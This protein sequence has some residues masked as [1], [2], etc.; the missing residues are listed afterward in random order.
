MSGYKIE[1][2]CEKCQTICGGEWYWSID[3]YG[4]QKK[5]ILCKVE[6]KKVNEFRRRQREKS[7]AEREK[8]E[9]EAPTEEEK[10]AERKEY[11]AKLIANHLAKME[12]WKKAEEAKHLA[13]I[14]EAEASGAYEVEIERLKRYGI[15]TGAQQAAAELDEYKR[16]IALEAEG[17]NNILYDEAF[18]N[19]CDEKTI[20]YLYENQYDEDKNIPPIDK[21]LDEGFGL[22]K[23]YIY[24]N[25][26]KYYCKMFR[27]KV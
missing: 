20:V 23:I 5:E 16:E 6:D 21:I 17:K 26:T 8:A 22:Y 13:Q 14:A 11:E 4:E 3:Y 27:E 7:I 9:R 15:P 12:D 18:L 10:E 25:Y 2:V 24:G 1:G 19:T